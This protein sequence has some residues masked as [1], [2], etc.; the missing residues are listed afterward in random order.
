MLSKRYTVV[1]A[2]RTTGVVRRFTLSVKPV[3]FTTIAVV[4]LPILIGTGAALKAQYDVK[5]LY[6]S[7]AT[8]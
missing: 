6:A 4:T 8:L 2:D 3:L 7:K 5:N 1:L